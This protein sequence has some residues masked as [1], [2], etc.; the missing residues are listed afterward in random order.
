MRKC[1]ILQLCIKSQKVYSVKV[2]L[3]ANDGCFCACDHHHQISFNVFAAIDIAILDQSNNCQ[4]FLD[5]QY[6]FE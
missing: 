2:L 3:N 1:I 5:L 6:S 4:Q